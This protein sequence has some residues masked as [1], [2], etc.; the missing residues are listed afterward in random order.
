MGVETG[1]GGRLTVGHHDRG[2]FVSTM[3][4]T[5]NDIVSGSDKF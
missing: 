5:M 3:N 4:E 2:V 1:V